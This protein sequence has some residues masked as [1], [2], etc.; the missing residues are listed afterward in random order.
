VTT[1]EKAAVT[2]AEETAAAAEEKPAEAVTLRFMM[3][4]DNP[5]DEDMYKK[6]IDEYMAANPNIKIQMENVPW[7]TFQ[8]KLKPQVIAGNPPD[9]AR[10]SSQWG[11]EYAEM[12]EL[13]DLSEFIESGFTDQFQTGRW[14]D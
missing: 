8:E 10:I 13:A 1:T 2:T 11:A 4:P 6:M 12:G 5:Q 9:I 3:F 7:N 14:A